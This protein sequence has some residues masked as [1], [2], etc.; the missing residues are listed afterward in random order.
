[1]DRVLVID[2]EET[3]L[4][5]VCRT[6]APEGYA[7][8]CITDD[9]VGLSLAASAD[10]DVVIADT[11]IPRVGGVKILREI[12]RLMPDV[13]V[14]IVTG[15]G[16]VQSAVRCLKEGASDYLEKPFQPKVLLE[17]VRR[18]LGRIRRS[19]TQPR[20]PRHLHVPHT[21]LS[22]AVTDSPFRS[23]HFET[24]PGGMEESEYVDPDAFRF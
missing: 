15:Y 14:I 19:K 2:N 8:D 16:D 6:L 4:E 18:A 20:E 12:K 9:G 10:Y 13:P 3:A 7:V 11:G 21:V 22:R 23:G 5:S 17:S 1:M 24:H